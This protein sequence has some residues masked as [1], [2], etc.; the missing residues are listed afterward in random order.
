LI[1]IESADPYIF[2]SEL[3]IHDVAARPVRDAAGI[4][5]VI[6]TW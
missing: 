3:W 6:E 4:V 1:K 5:Q 2:C